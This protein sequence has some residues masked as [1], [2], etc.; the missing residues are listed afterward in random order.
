MRFFLK[1]R[2]AISVGVVIAMLLTIL[3]LSTSAATAHTVRTTA[4]LNLRASAT[5]SSS[6]LKTLPTGTVMTL[7]E[8]SV[9]GW[10]H[11]SGGG[12]TGYASADFLEVPAGSD[13]EITA[14]ATDYVNLRSGKGTSYPAYTAIPQNVTVPVTDN[15]DENWAAVSYLNFSGYASKDYLVIN[16]KIPANTGST[17]PGTHRSASFSDLPQNTLSSPA[18]D[19]SGR[20][21]LNISSVTI[22]I[23][24]TFALSLVDTASMPIVGGVSYSSSSTSVASVTANGLVKGLKAGQASVTVTELST[25]S[26]HTC[27]ITVTSSVKPTEIETQP[28]TQPSTTV[29]PTQPSTQPAATLSL[30]ATSATVYNGCYYQIIANTDAS[31]SWSSSNTSVATVSSEGI[32]TA[33]SNGTAVITAKAGNQSATCKITV[34]SG[35]TVNLSHSSASITAGKTFLARSYSYNVTW[36]SS[37]PSVATVNNGYILAKS[38]GKTVVTVSTSK[39]AATMLVTVT[40]AAPIRFA[41]TSP[42]CAY[43]N[44]TVTLIAIT[45][46]QRTAVRFNVTVGST[47]RTVNATSSV[48]DGN[49]LVWKGTTS[50]S[51]AGTYKVAA[52]SQLGNTWT[53]C[54]DGSTTA[55]VSDTTDTMTTV[56]TARR[57]SD[58]VIK[59]IANF[60][61]Y[62]SSIYDDPITGDPTV[63]Y[64]RVIFS[65]QQFYNT[66]TRNEAFA[67]LVQTVN[68]DGY[69]SSVNSLFLNN[70]VKFNQ[71]QFDAL[72]CLVYNTG[73]GVLS[74][75]SELRDALLDCHDGL[76]GTTTYYINGSYVRLRKGPS[77]D[78]EIIDELSSGTL[79]TVLDMSNSAWYQVR[80]DDGRT[81]YVS[82][83]YIAKRSTGGNLD[84][85]YV[86]R[87]LLI[88]KFCAYHHAAG[89]CIYGL[90]YR[91]VDEM[92]MFF[93]G[94]YERNY[95]YY[96]YDINFTCVRNPSFH[97]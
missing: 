15:S 19:E 61:G 63:G 49:T 5:T 28:P 83:D 56:C 41:Y 69:S 53:T 91:R 35:D 37:D 1:N 96:Y 70:S 65:G 11:L 86:D 64:G 7:L 54:S 3:P 58:D 97:T 55:F 76:G 90:L 73:S 47:T 42:N 74:G 27:L 23:N 26:K 82:S 84:L 14:T 67:Y 92:E 81:G 22:D 93:Y 38:P 51:S 87:Q 85:N 16:L 62:I 9:D 4:D 33:Q 39:G 95:G 75:D 45:D 30:S 13:V 43:K 60:E 40:A 20:T 80:L 59:L 21:M 18:S 78:Q 31:V 50:F 32:V 36:T 89:D 52:Y 79:V 57:A 77:T 17:E 44:Q 8:D 2:A 88:N 66:M 46:Q 6:V 10:A 25:G 34:T 48:K 12:Y 29:A 71:Q 68:N 94:D 24:E 72:V